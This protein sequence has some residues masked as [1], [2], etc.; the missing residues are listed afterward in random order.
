MHSMGD[1]SAIVLAAG[2]S[3]RMGRPKMTLPL[4]ESTVIGTVVTNL[5]KGGLSSIRVV[6]GADRSGIAQALAGMP[7]G[8]RVMEV[9]N[10]DFAAGEM[11]SSIQAGL[12]SLSDE[13]QAAMIAL[14]DQPQIQPEVVQAILAAYRASNAPLVAPSYQMRRGHP[15]VVRREL[16]PA[17][18]ELPVQASP[19]Q[20]LASRANSIEYVVVDTPTILMD[21]DTPDDY[22]KLK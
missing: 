8:V 14:G 3:R 13:T 20:F 9:Y 21:L 7:A 19:R 17:L 15:W 4:G 5:A 22:A 1:L 2:Q 10:P 6:T 16:W 18:L 11:L 12:R